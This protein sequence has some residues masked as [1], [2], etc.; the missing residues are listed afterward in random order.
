MTIVCLYPDNPSYEVY[1]VPRLD[2]ELGLMLGE[3]KR[4][5]E[6][7]AKAKAEK[8]ARS[9]AREAAAAQKT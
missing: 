8:E 3:R 5:L 1:E 7:A 9:Q 6:Y 2:N 4:R